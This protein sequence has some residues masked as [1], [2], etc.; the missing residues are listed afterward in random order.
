MAIFNRSNIIAKK[1]KVAGSIMQTPDTGLDSM[2]SKIAAKRAAP[3]VQTGLT[4]TQAK[5]PKTASV[6]TQSFSNGDKGQMVAAGSQ[7]PRITS[8][9]KSAL[10]KDKFVLPQANDDVSTDSDSPN[11]AAAVNFDPNF[12]GQPVKADQPVLSP[13]DQRLNDLVDRMV[14]SSAAGAA[15][16][17]KAQETASKE[18]DVKNANLLE[19]VRAR[20]GAMGA[21]LLG[22]GAA[23]ESQ[24]T[25][26]GQRAKTLALDE[27]LRAGRGQDIQEAGVIGGLIGQQQG[28]DIKNRELEIRQG[29]TESERAAR[30]AE[31]KLRQREMDIRDKE[32]GY[33]EKSF[34]LALQELEN[35]LQQDLNGDGNIA[36]KTPEVKKQEEAKA[37]ETQ[38]AAAAG[39]NNAKATIQTIWKDPREM[40]RQYAN[41]KSAYAT[42]SQTHPGISFEQ[43]VKEHVGYWSSWEGQMAS[44]ATLGL[45]SAANW[46]AN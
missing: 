7:R 17:A 36:G 20:S 1:P 15:D 14:G 34:D 32:A 31:I 11:V 16:R 44:S 28:Q 38:A 26:E 8:D 22:A 39:D 4:Q 37:A 46:P 40:E 10:L 13:A 30:E 24:A 42:W 33:T 12:N 3:P 18:F 9:I 25:R 29:E 45:A 41:A 19:S 35:E 6:Q 21:G 43:Y 5:V 2:A 27:L 23:L